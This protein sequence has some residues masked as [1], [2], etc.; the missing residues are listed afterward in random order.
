MEF[1]SCCHKSENYS[2]HTKE[3]TQMISLAPNYNADCTDTIT[4]NDDKCTVADNC[5]GL[6]IIV[7]MGISGEWRLGRSPPELWCHHVAHWQKAHWCSRLVSIHLW[8]FHKVFYK[9]ILQQI[10]SEI[11]L[12]VKAWIY[13]DNN[14][15]WLP[16]RGICSG[17]GICK[18]SLQDVSS[19]LFNHTF[20]SV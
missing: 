5:I 15:L 3:D 10:C 9:Q 13:L 11:F 19:F 17:S 14:I 8:K 6:V 16:F 18:L 20:I 4:Y 2:F 1:R 12:P 7:E